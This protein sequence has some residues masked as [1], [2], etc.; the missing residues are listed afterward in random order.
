EDMS[1]T[2]P[3]GQK[4]VKLAPQGHYKNAKAEKIQRQAFAFDK[5]RCKVCPLNSDCIKSKQR[6]YRIVHL[7]PQEKLLQEARAF[8]QSDAF[9]EYQRMRQSVEH[10]LA[11]LV[12]LGIRQARYFGRRKTLFQLL[13]AA[14]VANLTLAAT[15]TGQIRSKGGS[16]DSFCVWILS[17]LNTFWVHVPHFISVFASTGRQIPTFRLGF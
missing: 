13:M 5:T 4:T 14:T 7:H 15:K 3:N 12:Q 11:R 9:K 16:K 2:C 6:Q 1:C 8:Q 17:T 10:R